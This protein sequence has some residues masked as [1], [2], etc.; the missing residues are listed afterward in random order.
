VRSLP[1]TSVSRRTFL[2]PLGAAILSALGAAAA[3][4]LVIP[5]AQAQVARRTDDEDGDDALLLALPVRDEQM[6][7]AHRSHSSHSSHRSHVSGSGGGGGG[8]GGGG[9]TFVAP[10]STPAPAPKPSPPPTTP[11]RTTTPIPTLPS[12]N[13][14]PAATDAVVAPTAPTP[15]TTPNTTAQDPVARSCSSSG[16]DSNGTGL[17]VAATVAALLGVRKRRNDE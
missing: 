7:L 2:I 16:Q 6:L 5:V 9:S 13:R 14:A 3:T 8:G 4:G 17:L 12:T 11:T 10:A 15:T 1:S